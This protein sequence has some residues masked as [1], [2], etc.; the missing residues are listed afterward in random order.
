MEIV[1][2]Q[3]LAGLGRTDQ[4]VVIF[5]VFRASN[6]IIALLA[7]G[8]DGVALIAGLD[9][10]YALKAAHPEWLLTGERGGLAQPGFDGDNSPMGAA[11]LNVAGRRVILT[12]SAG[13]QAVGSL[14]GAA[15]VYYG[16]FAN[17][18]ALTRHLL[19]QAPPRL[20]LLPMGYQARTPALEDDLAAWYLERSLLGAPPAFASIRERLLACDG[21]RR[22][23]ELG[24]EDDLEFCTRLNHQPVVPRVRYAQHPLAENV[25]PLA[26]ADANSPSII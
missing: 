18:A 21:A 19:A 16:S 17:A 20:A 1:T 12:T 22:L 14:A 25:A 2:R 9:Q 4:A 8:A 23:R 15:A 6:T 24:Q 7:A 3:G 10:A 11:G 26:G 13:T 5:D